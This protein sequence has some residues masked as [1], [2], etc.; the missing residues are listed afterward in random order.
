MSDGD[1]S[2]YVLMMISLDGHLTDAE[3]AKLQPLFDLR[4]VLAG[5]QNALQRLTARRTE[6][7]T[8]EQ[9]LRDNLRVVTTPGDLHEKLLAALQN[10]E[11]QLATLKTDYANAN[12][13]V[14]EAHAALADAVAKFEL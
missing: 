14:D 5:K 3:H 11:A 7:D 4:D 12:K 13:A 2:N 8:D 6:I 10:D 9:R 1:L